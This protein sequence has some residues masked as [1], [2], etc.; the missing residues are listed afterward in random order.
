MSTC[1]FHVFKEHLIF[2]H[3]ESNSGAETQL[4]CA[5][6]MSEGTL[7]SLQLLLRKAAAL[8]EAMCPKPALRRWHRRA[9]GTGLRS[10]YLP[11]TA[12]G[13]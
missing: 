11:S 9:L 6:Q 7:S 13:N 8:P 10:F 2:T 12:D 3:L 4:P 1:L 5:F